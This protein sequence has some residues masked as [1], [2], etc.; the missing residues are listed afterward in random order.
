MRKQRRHTA[1]TLIEAIIAVVILS[2]AIPPMLWSIHEAHVQ[3]VNPMLASRARWLA[4]EQLEDVIADRHST[5]R[6][7]DY[8][9]SANYPDESP[10]PGYPGFDRRVMFNETQADLATPGE[11]YMNVTVEVIWTDATSQS[12]TLTVSTVLTEYDAN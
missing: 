8:L 10:V 7:Y 5:T 2:L 6:G 11:G 12:R 9:T 1:F 3:R 4:T